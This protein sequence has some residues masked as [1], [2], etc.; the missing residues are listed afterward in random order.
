MEG[1]KR[2]GQ[3]GRETPGIRSRHRN[4]AKLIPLGTRREGAG[5][6]QDVAP[7]LGEFI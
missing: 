2:S 6:A 5:I 4:L 1:S 3:M 7:F